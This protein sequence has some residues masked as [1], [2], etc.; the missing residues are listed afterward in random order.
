MKNIVAIALMGLILTS[1]KYSNEFSKLKN[2]K[3]TKNALMSSSDFEL[4]EENQKLLAEYFGYTKSLLF[5]LQND[6]KMKKYIHKRFSKYFDN[7][8]CKN[9][10]I[11]KVFYDEIMNECTVNGFFV[12]ADEVQY[13]EEMILKLYSNLTEFEKDKINSELVCKELISGFD[14]NQGR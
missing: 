9:V 7:S 3:T 2:L 12:C 4:N 11:S 1:C 10:L 5:K 14:L 8:I 13:F 6:R